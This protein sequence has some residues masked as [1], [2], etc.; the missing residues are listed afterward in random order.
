TAQQD[1]PPR[2]R[3]IRAVFDHF[4]NLLPPE[5]RIVFQKQA[6]FRGGFT[7]EAFEAITGAD[8]SMLAR[9]VDKS[10]VH[11]SEN[12]RYRRHSLMVQYGTLRLRE[13]D[14]LCAQVRETH[15]R[16]FSKFVKQLE[17]E[18]IGGQPQKAMPLFL[19]DLPNIRL[20]WEWAVE[21]RDACVFNDMS[22]SFMQA[23]DLSGLYRD[24]FEMAIRA[25]DA[26]E[27]VKSTAKETRI[28]K[29]RV[30]GLV[31]AFLFRLGEYQRAIEH[32]LESMRL[33][34]A[35]RP[36][37]TYGHTLIYAGCASFGLGNLE[38]VIEYWGQA[39]HEYRAAK[40]KWG[41]MASTS[42]LAEAL[43]A[44]GRLEEAK[45]NAEYGLAL[46]REMNNLEQ[47]GGASTNLANWAIEEGRFEEATQYA[48]EAL[49]SHQQV[50][51]DAHIANSLAALAQIAFKQKNFDE[52][53]NLLEE[54]VGILKRVGNKLYLEQREQELA[55][56]MSALGKRE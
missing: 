56:V 33:L 7:R 27:T 24:G 15:A 34:E 22:D 2:H 38:K 35:I 25:S 10:A 47:I 54:S 51:H 8:L 29:G 18:F 36:H 32:C 4:W 13:N 6:V 31:G 23:F 17:K 45:S 19:A 9:F 42:N 12:G 39:V 48:E 28:A 53:R 1:L 5:E 16:Y 3:S 40:S 43:I 46:A 30:M 20:A 37:I 14:A 41:D 50:G 21:Q 49:R 55:E 44:V 52:A 11:F 26:L